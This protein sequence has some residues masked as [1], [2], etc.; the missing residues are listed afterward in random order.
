MISAVSA[1]KQ[2]AVTK[3]AKQEGKAVVS[4]T[5]RTGIQAREIS[6]LQRGSQP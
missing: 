4:E 6:F 3:R 2:T 1:L 5:V